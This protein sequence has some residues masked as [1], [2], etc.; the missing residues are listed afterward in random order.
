MDLF[1]SRGASILADTTKK[2][3]TPWLLM[4]ERLAQNSSFHFPLRGTVAFLRRPQ[5]RLEAFSMMG[6]AFYDRTNITS[7]NFVNHVS[8]QST[9]L[10]TTIR[11][12][13]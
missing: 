5:I 4:P 6:E 12:R 7:E 2:A 10:L 9:P 11:H 1:T 3:S 8:L 13:S